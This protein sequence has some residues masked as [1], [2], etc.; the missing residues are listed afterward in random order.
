MDNGAVN[1]FRLNCLLFLISFDLI[2][3][4]TFLRIGVFLAKVQDLV[5]VLATYLPERIVTSYIE[6]AKEYAIFP[7]MFQ[8]GM[9]KFTTRFLWG[10]GLLVIQ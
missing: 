7:E 9:F 6:T 2:S 8:F 1:I 4:N 10:R 3:L 5:Q